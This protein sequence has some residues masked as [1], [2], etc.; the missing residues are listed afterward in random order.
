MEKTIVAA[1]NIGDIYSQCGISRSCDFDDNPSKVHFL[2]FETKFNEITYQLPTSLLLNEDMEFEGFGYEA[3]QKYTFLLENGT[4][5]S[6]YFFRRFRMQLHSSS[7]YC[8]D[9]DIYTFDG[10]KKIPMVF[11]FSLVIRFFRLRVSSHLSMRF[12]VVDDEISWIL[13]FPDSWTGL[14]ERLFQEAARKGGLKFG[15]F[16]TLSESTAY[17]QYCKRTKEDQIGT[18]LVIVDCGLRHIFRN[19]TMTELHHKS[20][21]I[22]DGTSID[23]DIRSLLR[24]V[25]G[26]DI[27]CDDKNSHPERDHFLR[28]VQANICRNSLPISVKVPLSW[29][30]RIQMC[31][32]DERY[33]D[34]IYLTGDKL[35]ITSTWIF[36]S[37]KAAFSQYMEKVNRLIDK[38]NPNEVIIMGDLSHIPIVTQFVRS[39][40]SNHC[41]KSVEDKLAAIEGALV[42]G[43]TPNLTAL[44][45]SKYKFLIELSQSDLLS[46]NH[47]NIGND[48][49]LRENVRTVTLSSVLDKSEYKIKVLQNR[50]QYPIKEVT[51]DDVEV[52]EKVILLSDPLRQIVLEDKHEIAD[53]FSDIYH[54]E[55]SDSLES[56]I[57]NGYSEKKGVFLLIN[58]LR[59]S[60]SLICKFIQTQL[61]QVAA[62]FNPELNDAECS[63]ELPDEIRDEVKAWQKNNFKEYIPHV[64]EYC[65][66]ELS[67]KSFLPESR[68]WL[69]ANYIK[70]IVANVWRMTVSEPEMYLYWT[71]QENTKIDNSVVQLFNKSGEFLDYV[72]WPAIYDGK[73]EILR[74][75][76]VQA[77]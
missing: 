53:I 32:E 64:Q 77:K 28:E 65:E 56:L 66:N 35:R 11:I 42:F 30:Q 39:N 67:K 68:N 24:A 13:T 34:T 74:K 63:F 14:Y 37:F 2:A 58:I 4:H 72:V 22:W 52:Q 18:Q 59:E 17:I 46:V 10:T 26:P 69:L 70:S 47:V 36:E 16:S 31:M 7:S 61:L 54:Q 49:K 38:T 50:I 1:I 9:V 21:G 62:I 55:W 60:Q 51:F 73:D 43:H 71:F 12:G 48:N 57:K 25:I 44:A 75:A 15:C 19:E 8:S 29:H 40:I 41:G 76:I 5:K 33:K 20:I 45:D 23:R 3:E 6:Y 27:Y